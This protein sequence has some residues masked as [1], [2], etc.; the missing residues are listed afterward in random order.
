MPFF[1]NPSP[2][3]TNPEKYKKVCFACSPTPSLFGQKT[4]ST[5]GVAS[6]RLNSTLNFALAEGGGSTSFRLNS[7][8]AEGGGIT[9][10]RFNCALTQG[11]GITSLRL[12]CA[13]AER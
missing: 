6:I 11:G 8:L 2:E 3:L 12:N 13:V 10:L 9:S 5:V 4:S 1:T 7:A